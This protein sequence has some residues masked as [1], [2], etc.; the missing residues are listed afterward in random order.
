MVKYYSPPST[1]LAPV[2]NPNIF[3]KPY[4][5]YSIFKLGEDTEVRIENLSTEPNTFNT[6]KAMNVVEQGNKADFSILVS[7]SDIGGGGTI[8]LVKK[9]GIDGYFTMSNGQS[10]NGYFNLIQ[11]DGTNSFTL[12]LQN[13]FLVAKN[14]KKDLIN[15]SV[16][17]N[18]T[19]STINGYA[20]LSPLPVYP[21][22]TDA[23]VDLVPGMLYKI[24]GTKEVKQVE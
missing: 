23:L 15:F 24:T 12:N 5:G 7:F 10:V 14:Y 2:Q 16:Q 21:N 9:Y 13:M 4:D 11:G 1:P 3:Y 17:A 8:N 22:N 20:I 18:G 19:L 6:F